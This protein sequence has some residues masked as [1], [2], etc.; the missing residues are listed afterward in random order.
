MHA[1]QAILCGISESG[2]RDEQPVGPLH[3]LGNAGYQ[4]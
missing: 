1:N 4:E 3:A 2:F